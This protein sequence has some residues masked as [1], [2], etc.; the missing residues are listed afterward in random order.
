MAGKGEEEN[1]G[2]KILAR[3]QACC[4]CQ[5]TCSK[6]QPQTASDNFNSL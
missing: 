6:K 4:E 1:K 3:G 5:A 2:E